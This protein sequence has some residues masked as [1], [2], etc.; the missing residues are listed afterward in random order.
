M[1]DRLI[2]RARLDV[3][4]PRLDTPTTIARTAQDPKFEPGGK[5]ACKLWH[6]VNS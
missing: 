6:G 4:V 3:D 2:P 1:S 5:H